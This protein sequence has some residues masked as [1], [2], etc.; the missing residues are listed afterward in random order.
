[1]T[2]KFEKFSN[3]KTGSERPRR[4]AA[5]NTQCLASGEADTR[6]ATDGYGYLRQ[7]PKWRVRPILRQQYRLVAPLGP[8]PHHDRAGHLRGLQVL[9]QQR[10]RWSRRY[11]GRRP[12]EALQREVDA[13][14]TEAYAR[15]YASEREMMPDEPCNACAGTGV[16]KNVRHRDADENPFPH[17]GVGDLKEGGKCYR[18]QGT[19]YIRP[20][21]SEYEFSTENV[22]DFIAFLR[23][24]GGFS[25]W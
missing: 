1:M 22:T 15:R 9:A 24:S 4:P 5:G 18:C 14:R 2:G 3:L 19:G 12:G 8:L 11:G 20:R 16:R 25:I 10:R 17:C 13:G 7:E 23:K 6:G 21:T